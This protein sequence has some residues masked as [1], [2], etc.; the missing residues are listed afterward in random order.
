MIFFFIQ[1][2]QKKKKYELGDTFFSI[3][4]DHGTVFLDWQ[5]VKCEALE[6]ASQEASQESSFFRRGSHEMSMVSRT[7]GN[8]R[9]AKSAVEVTEKVQSTK[10]AAAIRRK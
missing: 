10:Q 6:E 4:S 9:S 5:R 8:S 2:K 7:Q 3:R 1:K